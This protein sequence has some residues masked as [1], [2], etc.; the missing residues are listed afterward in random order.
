MSLIAL[1]F[2][3]NAAVILLLSIYPL[4][5]WLRAVFFARPVQRSDEA[6]EPVTIIIACNNEELFI[7]QK[8]GSF[9]NEEEWIKGSELIVISNGSTDGTNSI[10]AE[11]AGDPRVKVIIEPNASS[12]IRSVNRGVKES[13]HELLLFSDCRQLMKT[14]SVKAL[15]ANFNDPAVGTVNSTL[16]DA[17]N[18]QKRSFRT[19]LNFIRIAKAAAALR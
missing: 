16:I 9:L 6:V 11:Y 19:L 3:I 17:A 8:I 4:V 13:K 14:G 15:L 7:R 10:L 5:A 18:G 2:F 1:F 12:K